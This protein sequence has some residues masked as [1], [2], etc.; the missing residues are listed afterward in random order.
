[1]TGSDVRA[2]L[3]IADPGLAKKW[4]VQPQTSP[5]VHFKQPAN[6]NPKPA[7]S[8]RITSKTGLGRRFWSSSATLEDFQ[9]HHS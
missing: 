9:S 2:K 8:H 5:D 6:T 1:M 7:N 4:R 3:R